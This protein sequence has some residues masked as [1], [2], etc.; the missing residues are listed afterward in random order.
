MIQPKDLSGRFILTNCS[1]WLYE[2][3]WLKRKISKPA[4]AERIT[5]FVSAS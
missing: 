1:G 5:K 4:E 2:L 3:G